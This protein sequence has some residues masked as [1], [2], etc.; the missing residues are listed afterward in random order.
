MLD[1]TFFNIVLDSN[2][3]HVIFLDKYKVQVNY[4][5]GSVGVIQMDGSTQQWHH[6]PGQC[7]DWK[8]SELPRQ[9][10]GKPTCNVCGGDGVVQRYNLKDGNHPEPCPSCLPPMTDNWPEDYELESR[11]HLANMGQ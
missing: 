8:L 9:T 2:V 11:K 1:E 6:L 5:D 4:N 10:F 7:E 3:A